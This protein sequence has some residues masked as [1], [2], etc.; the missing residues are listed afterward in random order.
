MC[1]GSMPVMR[2][3]SEFLEANMT[4]Q[5]LLLQMLE[6]GVTPDGSVAE[7]ERRL[8]EAGFES[9]YYG[10]NW[11]LV[12]GGKYVLNHNDTALFGFTVGK[13][14]E[15][16][17]MVRMAAAHTD[18]PCFRIKPN[19]DF[20]T[21][22]Y[23][24]VNVEVYGGPIVNTW[25]DRPLGVAGRV[26]VR[27]EEPF[28][29][30]MRYFKSEKPLMTIPNVA[31]HLNPKINSGVELNRQTD[32]MPILD[33][34]PGEEKT[35]GYFLNYLAKELEVAKEDI[36]DFELSVYCFENPCYVGPE[37]KLLSAPR[38]DNQT[39]VSALVS[40]LIGGERAKGVNLIA[41]FDHE[42]VGSGSKQGAASTLLKELVS[43]ILLNLGASQEDVMRV[44]YD[45]M[46]LS[47]DVAHG[48]HPNHGGKYDIT[49]HPV[50]GKGFCIK[51]ACCQTYATDPEAIAILCQICDGAKVPYQR[52]LNRSD[53]RGGSTLG[54]IASSLFP[55]KTVDIGVPLLAMHSARELMGA[56]D[57]DALVN[58]VKAFFQ[59]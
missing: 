16:G 52:F 19:G 38:L 40:A 24:Q 53:I 25:L 49:N 9:L 4:E 33:L 47:V 43:R 7:S 6:A 58:G 34:I 1:M 51:E 29:P 23:A 27:S 31:I 56:C 48:F 30:V 14:Y 28:A 32:L 41:L 18:H 50:L 12:P 26:A 42:E 5:E 2:S 57:Q 36:L 20:Q 11:E 46:M 22:V 10:E 54:A 3:T 39:S 15:T 35:N 55:M 21:D 45:S 44:C 17:Q 37:G 8:L 59:A 13:D